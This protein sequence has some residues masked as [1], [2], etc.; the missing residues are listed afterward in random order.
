MAVTKTSTLWEWIGGIRSLVLLL[1]M[2]STVAGVAKVTL[3]R[4]ECIEEDFVEL[5]AD[6]K[7]YTKESVETMQK[8]EQS[9]IRIEERQNALIRTVQ[10]MKQR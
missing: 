8:I 9:L 5:K 6:Y 1:V 4:V 2:L 7:T 10:E 3:Y